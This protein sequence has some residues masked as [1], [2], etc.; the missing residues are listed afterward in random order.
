M[1]IFIHCAMIHNHQKKLQHILVFLRSSSLFT[2]GIYFLHD[3]ENSFKV[4]AGKEGKAVGLGQRT[5][6]KY[7]QINDKHGRKKVATS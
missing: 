2:E 6:H 1:S 3:Q 4:S 5:I 7:I